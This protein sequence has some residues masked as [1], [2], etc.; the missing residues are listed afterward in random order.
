MIDSEQDTSTKDRNSEPTVILQEYDGIVENFKKDLLV[1]KAEQSNILNQL[2][3]LR[4]DSKNTNEVIKQYFNEISQTFNDNKSLEEKEMIKNLQERLS[5]MQMEKDSTSQ[6]WQ[7]SLKAV[8]SLENE[9]KASQT[10]EKGNKYYEEQINSIR[11]TYSDAIKTLEEKLLQAKENFIKQQSVYESN[12]EKLQSLTKEKEDIVEKLNQ[13]QRE[14][15]QKEVTLEQA[16]NSLKIELASAKADIAKN[17]NLKSEFEAKLQE[18]TKFATSLLV[19]DEETKSKMKETL[20]LVE[21][22]FKE[23]EL[24]LQKE[25]QANEEKKK[26]E[27]RLSNI[28]EEYAQLMDK[29]MT[30]VKEMNHQSIKKYLIEIKE[31]K[32]EL[33]ET[34]TLLDRA[35]R[36]C[37]L[38]EDELSKNRKNS[39]DSL[40]RSGARI[41]E[42]EE[43]LKYLELQLKMAD[44]VH[45]KKYDT[46]IKR[47]EGRIIELK[48]KLDAST[49]KLKEIQQENAYHNGDLLKQAGDETKEANERYST[50]E[51]KLVRSLDEKESLM[52]ELRALQNSF[53]REIQKREHEKYFLEHKIRD[54]EQNFRNIAQPIDETFPTDLKR[55]FSAESVYD[56]KHEYCHSALSDQLSKLQQKFDKRT[57]ELSEHVNVHQKLSKRW[58]EEAKCLATK[59]QGKTKDLRNKITAL[60]KENEELNKELLSCRQ[61]LAQCRIQVIH[62]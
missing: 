8:N 51:K 24:A 46:Q 50:L 48:E 55:K 33:R 6:L 34:A 16:I 57:M 26:L 13:L 19:K 2:D 28:A 23:K 31:L 32:T 39:E 10:N 42:L 17:A 60:N 49:F 47:L 21:T 54:L 29:E 1:C 40:L 58:K 12:K 45:R 36:D 20:E 59:F 56:N 30:K 22:A 62:S 5:I 4:N 11:E 35:K 27:N 53:D 3:L 7:M 61:Q 43:K 52:N 9:L 25:A 41:N 15:L 37:R 38:A 14:A 18:A 44:D